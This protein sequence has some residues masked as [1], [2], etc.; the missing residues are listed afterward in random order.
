VDTKYPTFEKKA[1]KDTW[2]RDIDFILEPRLL[3][4]FSEKVIF[5]S[6]FK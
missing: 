3:S 4:D 5:S 2:T 6:S 1:A